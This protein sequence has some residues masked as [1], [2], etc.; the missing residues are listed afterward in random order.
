[1]L[2]S[3]DMM[4]N[5]IDSEGSYMLGQALVT[6]EALMNLNLRLNNLGD[7]GGSVLLEC[8]AKNKTLR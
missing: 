2:C 5:M 7:V 1:V 3:L 6:N 4:G 8:L